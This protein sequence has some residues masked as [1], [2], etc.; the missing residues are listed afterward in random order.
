MYNI[1]GL[2]F[3]VLCGLVTSVAA[4]DPVS[5]EAYASIM[6]TM[7]SGIAT[8]VAKPVT[9]GSQQLEIPDCLTDLPAGSGP[10]PL[11]DEALAESLECMSGQVI[12][13]SAALVAADN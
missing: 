5:D 10:D 13:D 3:A 1:I 7:A 8:D 6:E 11:S 9:T 4:Q 12:Y 2:S